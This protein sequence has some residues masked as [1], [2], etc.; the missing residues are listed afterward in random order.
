MFATRASHY[1]GNTAFRV[2]LLVL[3]LLAVNLIVFQRR[4]RP[5]MGDA[6]VETGALPAAVGRSAA[7]SLVLWTVAVLAGR[8]I[9]HS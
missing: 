3:L 9:G 2:K 8:W 5:R 1:A 7:V 4:V 6:A